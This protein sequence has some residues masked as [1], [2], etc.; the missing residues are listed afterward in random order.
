MLRGGN[1]R[2]TCSLLL[3]TSPGSRQQDPKAGKERR[4]E[5]GGG[6]CRLRR[7]PSAPV[8]RKQRC[9]W[10]RGAAGRRREG[11]GLSAGSGH[12]AP[13]ASAR[14]RRRPEAEGGTVVPAG[15]GC[16]SQVAAR[17]QLSEMLQGLWRSAK[18]PHWSAEDSRD[19]KQGGGKWEGKALSLW[20]WCTEPRRRKALSL[21]RRKSI[22]AHGGGGVPRIGVW[23]V[24]V[25]QSELA[26]PGRSWFSLGRNF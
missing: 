24:P 10:R 16:C 12:R 23:P 2:W 18:E 11:P 13:P 25:N 8:G 5:G 3:G 4:S 22:E 21:E 1:L 9:Y 19:L 6:R 17:A 15:W 26:L 14:R 7:P 20:G